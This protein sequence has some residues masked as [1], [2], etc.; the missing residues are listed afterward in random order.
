MSR[1]RARA[2]A[3]ALAL[4]VAL[5]G[6]AAA[7]EAL[8]SV[9]S[10]ISRGRCATHDGRAARA[11]AAGDHDPVVYR[12][13]TLPGRSV[14]LRFMGAA[15]GLAFGAPAKRTTPM[16][17]AT[18]YDVGPRIEWRGLGAGAAFQPKAAILRLVERDE[19]GKP[20]SALAILKVEG[21]EVCAAGFVDG[22]RADANAAARRLADDIAG[23]FACGAT[24]RVVGPL[25]PAAQIIF[26]RNRN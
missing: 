8:V 3:G 26:E 2:E 13:P 9:Y 6:G 1:A 25:S 20:G 14:E 15:V 4:V 11:R 7:Q 16:Q 10:D 23:D 12:C 18:G 22:A 19:T 24:P 17:L 5:C 21:T